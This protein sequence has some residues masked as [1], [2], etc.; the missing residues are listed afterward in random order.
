MTKATAVAAKEDQAGNRGPKREGTGKRRALKAE[1]AWKRGQVRKRRRAA[2][3]RPIP[4]PERLTGHGR[5]RQFVRYVSFNAF[6]HRLS[7]PALKRLM[8]GRPLPRCMP[9]A[10]VAEGG[11][12]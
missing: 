7:D 4:H 6:K 10:G 11:R 1:K 3:G 9:R 12:R 2:E 8:G 5:M